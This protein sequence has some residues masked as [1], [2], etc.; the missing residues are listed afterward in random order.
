MHNSQA[1]PE[2]RRRLREVRRHESA[3]QIRHDV[4]QESQKGREDYPA[5]AIRIAC[6]SVWPRS[7]FLSN[8]AIVNDNALSEEGY[9]DIGEVK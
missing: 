2:V 4:V 3:I 1:C 7:F 5:E 8:K 9:I 6:P